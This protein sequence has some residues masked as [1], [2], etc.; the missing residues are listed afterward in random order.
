MQRL[1]VALLQ[2]T[3]CGNDQAA[4]L[5]KGEAFCRRARAMG[6]DI[7][8]FPEMWNIGYTPAHPLPDGRDTPEDNLW[9]APEKW[10]DRDECIRLGMPDPAIV[11]SEQA[12]ERDGPFIRHFQ[13][14]ARELNMAIAIT[15]LEQWSGAPR[16][17]L[18]LID[19]HGRLALTYAKIHT[20]AFSWGEAALT[21][22]ESAEVCTLDTEQGPVQVGAMI[23]Y[24]REFPETARLLMLQGAE[25]VL[26]PNACELESNR[27][28]QFRT[29]AYENMVGMAMTNYATPQENGHSIAFDG[30]GFGS[31]GSRNMLLIEAGEGEGIYLATFDLEALR[32]FRLREAWGN[33][34][35]RPHLYRA[36][37]ESE[38]RSPFVRV[39]AQGEHWDRR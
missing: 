25:I 27:L 29:R 3:S 20:C 33:A 9:R 39:N 11:W 18:S 4:N 8:L 23:C 26:V 31:E 36:L 16:N 15:Y 2:M 13:Q 1:H 35:R 6:A 10:Q 24:D 14:L 12:I 32:D 28:A 30:I 5:T 7:A 17:S 19:R 38:A 37:T 22:G 34:F 21:P